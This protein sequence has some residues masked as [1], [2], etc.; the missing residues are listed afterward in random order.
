MLLLLTTMPV[1]N[2]TYLL[3]GMVIGEKRSN[4]VGHVG[5]PV[6][7]KKESFNDGSHV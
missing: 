2:E 7:N 1:G 6:F 5:M 4:H 3:Y